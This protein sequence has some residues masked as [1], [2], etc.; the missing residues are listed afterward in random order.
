MTFI[1]D[2]PT[3]GPLLEQASSRCQEI[4]QNGS[5]GTM[6][7]SGFR[8]TVGLLGG[9]VPQELCLGQPERNSEIVCKQDFQ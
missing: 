4:Y 6:H 7:S 3:P 5:I 1:R 2:S 9:D 8:V